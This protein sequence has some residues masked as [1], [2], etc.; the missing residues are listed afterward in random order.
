VAI[1]TEHTLD[2]VGFYLLPQSNILVIGR[3]AELVDS[4][5]RLGHTVT[6]AQEDSAGVTGGYCAI[7]FVECLHRARDL[8]AEF[9]R[10]DALL[11]ARGV[12]LVEDFAWERADGPTAVWDASL[13]GMSLDAAAA[14]AKW[15]KDHAAFA[16]GEDMQR[17]AQVRFD[18]VETGECPYLYRRAATA[19]DIA[20]QREAKAIE[21]GAIRAVGWRLVIH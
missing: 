6:S 20:F 18:H 10:V 8:A 4:L 14:L 11:S 5:R 17:A 15:R 16:T 21:T 13:R 12:V 3:A 19:P 7:V 1:A 2:F 9:S